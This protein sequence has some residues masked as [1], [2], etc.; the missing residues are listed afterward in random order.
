MNRISLLLMGLLAALQSSTSLGLPEDRLQPIQ[1][2]ADHA[3]LDDR[4]GVAIYTGDVRLVQGSL[5]I[6]ADLL[7]IRS[8][9]KG[10]QSLTAIGKPAHYRQQPRPDE[11]LTH[12]YGLRIEYS[13]ENNQVALINQ[14]RLERAADSFQGD[15]IIIDTARDLVNATSADNNGGQRVEMVIQPRTDSQ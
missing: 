5:Q 15:K 4:K 14:A 2:S 13:V 1:I 3:E 9:G 7:T 6:T 8:D 12:G 10:V 11:P